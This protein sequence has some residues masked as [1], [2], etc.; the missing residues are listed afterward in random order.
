[1]KSALFFLL[2]CGSILLA[3]ERSIPFIVSLNASNIVPPNPPSPPATITS[4]TLIGSNLVYRVAVPRYA[5]HAEIHG[6]AGIGTNGPLIFRL[7]SCGTYGNSCVLGGTRSLQDD[8]ISQLLAGLWY[9]ETEL[10]HGTSDPITTPLER[11]QILPDRDSDGIPDYLDK[12]PDTPAGASIR[13]DGCGIADLCPC[14]GAWRNHGEYVG[15]VLEVSATFN[16]Q[17]LITETERREIVRN[18]AESDCGK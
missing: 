16:S 12:C 9:V 11:G 4:F 7:G 6:P 15:A 18:A 5:F 3:E 13:A 8:Q 1:V 10:G 2:F 14:D 17:G